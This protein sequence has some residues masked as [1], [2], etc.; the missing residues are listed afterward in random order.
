MAQVRPLP[1]TKA[2]L[3]RKLLR[4]KKVRDSERAFVLEGE[5]PLRELLPNPSIQIRML[6]VTPTFMQQ[7]EHSFLRTLTQHPASVYLCTETFFA[8][9][10]DVRTAPGLLA[11]IEKPRW[12]E[13]EILGRPQLFGVYGEQLQDPTNVGTLIRT[14]VAFGVDALWLS[15][16]SADPYN[17]KVARGTAGTLLQ[18]PIFVTKDAAVFA[19]HNCVLLAAESSGSKG[20]DIRAITRI[21]Q[22]TIVALGNESRGLSDATLKHAAARFHI[23]I[24]PHVD[25]LNVAA[26][27]AICLFH[28]KHLPRQP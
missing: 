9:L 3:I 28:L 4:D 16:D 13:R 8:K 20:Q 19:Q 11:V 27:A 24:D 22:R 17:P 10:S 1:T 5:K 2:T 18:L 21:S 12:D 7:T 6:V 26:A 25:S 14:A 15:P 23:P